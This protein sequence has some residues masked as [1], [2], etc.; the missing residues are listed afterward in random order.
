M[1]KFSWFLQ[2]TELMQ[3]NWRF[4]DFFKL[5]SWCRSNNSLPDFKKNRADAV[6]SQVSLKQD[7]L[8]KEH[9]E[10]LLDEMQVCLDNLWLLLVGPMR[11][12]KQ[13]MLRQKRMASVI[14]VLLPCAKHIV[15]AR[16]LHCSNIFKRKLR[17]QSGFL[18]ARTFA[19]IC[20]LEPNGAFQGPYQKVATL[21]ATALIAI[22]KQR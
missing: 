13:Q 12:S 18:S 2:N 16:C 14:R 15:H 9:A 5:P 6:L 3:V 19:R 8:F 17:Q 1:K 7:A 4:P 22:H 21:G 20:A 10:V 11:N